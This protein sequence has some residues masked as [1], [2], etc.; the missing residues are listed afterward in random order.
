[1]LKRYGYTDLIIIITVLGITLSGCSA[2]RNPAPEVIHGSF[3][4]GI[5]SGYAVSDNKVIVTTPKIDID[6]S[7]DNVPV[8]DFEKPAISIPSVNTISPDILIKTPQGETFDE[9]FES[10]EKDGIS[11]TLDE[12]A[13]TDKTAAGSVSSADANLTISI[14]SDRIKDMKVPQ[15]QETPLTLYY[16]M[17]SYSYLGVPLHGA[18]TPM[19]MINCL[20][21]FNNDGDCTL[22]ETLD[23]ASRLGIW[24]P[25]DGMSA[26][27]IFISVAA[28]NDL[29]GTANCAALFGPKDCD[30]L[31]DIID[32]GL[33]AGVCVDSSM[34]WKGAKDGYADHMIA[35]LKTDRDKYGTLK[36]FEIIDS[37]MGLTYISADLYDE[38]ALGNKLGFVMVFGN[39]ENPPY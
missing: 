31:G 25:V 29:H 35:I 7:R 33:T 6:L 21:S 18:C 13:K 37:G 22:T 24:S 5:S 27:G 2:D 28:L 36:G 3:S 26:E 30:E 39:P 4:A 14:S 11:I 10:M 20:N 17:S 38:C 1:M 32:K 16:R 19:T 34:L 23:L 15:R 9:L 8:P 12:S